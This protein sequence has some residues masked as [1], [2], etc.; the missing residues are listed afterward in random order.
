MRSLPIPTIGMVLVHLIHCY[1]LILRQWLEMFHIHKYHSSLYDITPK[2]RSRFQTDYIRDGLLIIV[3]IAALLYC[4]NLVVSNALKISDMWNLSG[5]FIGTVIIGV[6]TALPELTV[7]LRAI[8]KGATGISLG[9]LIG[10]NITNPMFAL[11]LGAMISSYQVPRPIIVYD[12]PVKIASAILLI[13]FLWRN[14]MFTR[15]EAM[16]MIG[17]YF[18]YILVRLKYFAV[19]I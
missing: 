7:A 12:L 11:G 18:V 16:V 15:K 6:S 17:I 9:T 1:L 14:Q 4:A 19:D 13:W 8:M 2:E 3:G 10:S 5:S